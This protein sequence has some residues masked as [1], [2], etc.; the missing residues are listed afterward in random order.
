MPGC[1][2]SDRMS[3]VMPDAR[4]QTQTFV[5]PDQRY[6]GADPRTQTRHPGAPRP[7]VLEPTAQYRR[8]PR[9]GR[10]ARAMI[11]LS[12]WAGLVLSVGLWWQNTPVASIDSPGAALIEAGRI[13][14]MAAGYILL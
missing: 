1:R 13:T 10:R 9:R 2:A 11:L 12:F 6:R 7:T 14:G 4:G 8:P 5:R 3:G